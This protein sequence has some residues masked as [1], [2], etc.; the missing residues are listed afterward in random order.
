M[1]QIS[2]WTTCC[3]LVIVSLFSSCS[4]E[5]PA[6]PAGAQGPAGPT[7]ATGVAG[8]Q[9][10][11]GTANVIYSPWLDV[12]YSRPDTLHYFSA[13]I[14]ATKLN[15]AMLT[16]GEIKIY[17]NWQTAADPDVTPL[18]YFDPGGLFVNV[19]FYLGEID[20]YSNGNLSTQGT[21]T[22]KAGQVRYILIPGGAPA[23]M[24]AP[25]DWNDYKQ[26][27]AYLGLKD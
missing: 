6:G 14:Q 27:Q 23:R 4:K 22:S 5:G 16:S 20:L 11:A 2:L 1:K 12:T 19:D 10:P 18:P 3:L 21:G 17:M 13:V 25:I 9:G 7:G 26:V 15:A 8:P 24:A